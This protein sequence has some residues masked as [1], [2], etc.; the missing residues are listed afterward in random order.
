VRENPLNQFPLLDARDHF[1]APE[2]ARTLLELDPE[3]P[4]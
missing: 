3:H 4:F 1:Q 2:A